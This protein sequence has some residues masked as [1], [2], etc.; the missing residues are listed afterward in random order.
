MKLLLN[1]IKNIE[2]LESHGNVD[3]SISAISLSNK[4]IV[5]NAL[6]TAIVG[7]VTDGHKF[8]PDVISKGAKVI[9][10]QNEL[11]NYEH[12]VTYV[13]VRDTKAALGVI[14]HNFYDRP[15]FKLKLFGITGTNGKTT[16]ATLLHQLFL[17]L[18]HKTGMIGTVVNKI[19]DKSID[20]V[21]TTPDQINLNRLLAEM[22]D[23]GCEYC[24]MEVSSHAVSEKRISGLHFAGGVFTNLTHDHLDYH[25]T[26]ENYFNTKKTFFDGLHEA[27]F[28]LSNIDDERGRDMVADTKAKKYFYGLKTHADFFNRLETKL[29][30]EFNAYNALAVYATAHILGMDSEK[31]K[32][33]LAE[34]EPV[35]GRFNY[36]KSANGVTGIVDYAHTPDALVNVLKTVQEMKKD[37]KIITVVG[38]GGDRDKAKRPIMAKIAY[39]MSDIVILTSDNPRTENVEDILSDMKAGIHSESIE[40]NNVVHII[41]DRHM[42]IAMACE[43]TQSGDFILLAGKGHEKYQEV[44]GVKNHFD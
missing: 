37:G 7:N 15:S 1:V 26:I 14:A 38:C 27:S 22:V 30:G 11:E 20:A 18:G 28:V 3:I 29:L 17:N 44:N 2:V 42:A 19:N 33:I 39:D 8:I 21:R 41:E 34:L 35:E 9:V 32:N 24:F 23:A 31:I 12:G 36:F 25:K 10:Y 5:E 43:L 4:D 13:R 6:F 16:T 40:V